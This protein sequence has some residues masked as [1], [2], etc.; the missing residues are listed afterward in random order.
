MFGLMRNF[1]RHVK[2][3][4][5]ARSY[6]VLLLGLDKAGKTTCLAALKGEPTEDASQT[7]GFNS[8]K[9]ELSKFAVEAYDVGGGKSIRG[10]WEQYV[11]CTSLLPRSLSRSPSSLSAS[12]VK[13]Q[14]A[15]NRR[16]Q[17]MGK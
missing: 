16:G 2:K 9:F 14:E 1:Y 11:T 7:W 6:T 8:E 4:R 15:R 12:D 10:I 3:K 5:A 17:I 13:N